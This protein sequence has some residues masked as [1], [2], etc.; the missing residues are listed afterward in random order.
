M[1]HWI[2]FKVWF[3]YSLPEYFKNATKDKHFWLGY[4]LGIVTMPLL[5]SL[6]YSFLH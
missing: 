1:T 3:L 2:I 6:F 5:H 4:I